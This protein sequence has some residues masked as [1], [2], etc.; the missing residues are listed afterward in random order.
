[1][2]I[3]ARCAVALLMLLPSAT[4]AHAQEP[5]FR[6][7][8]DA[9]NVDVLAL[10][11]REP[12]RGL[13]ADDFVLTDNG[14]AQRLASVDVPG[15][16]HVIVVL[17]VSASVQGDTLARLL[18]AVR[19]LIRSLGE[20]DRVSVV[21]FSDRV[22]ILSR[23]A[24][25]TDAS[26][27]LDAPPPASGGTVLHDALVVASALSFADSRPS[28][29]LAFTDGADTASVTGA[30]A[31][32]KSLQASNTVVFTMAAGLERNWYDDRERRPSP[33][34]ASETWLGAQA[35]DVPR[36]LDRVATLTGGTFVQ[37]DRVNDLDATF[38]DIV[39]RYRA[40]YV[41]SYTP[42]GVGRED[43]W[44]RIEVRLKNQRGDVRAREGYL[45]V[46]S[47]GRGLRG[48]AR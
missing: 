24:T 48:E 2:S 44:H 31:L 39:A 9:V 7:T 33:Y 13:T 1:M 41:L 32:L 6:A 42:A 5:M 12:I 15:H 37:V 14:V 43:G 23:A 17:D 18:N 34:L 21:A 26:A 45:A 40:R 22:R 36:L 25:P 29:A 46:G 10:R 16:A 38:M 11:G 3:P 47:Q 35:A 4:L 20:D 27:S 28:V 19:A 30:A 8:A